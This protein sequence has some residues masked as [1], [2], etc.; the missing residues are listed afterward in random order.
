MKA[1]GLGNRFLLLKGEGKM[2]NAPQVRE[3]F[4]DASDRK[5]L[6]AARGDVPVWQLN[7][8]LLKNEANN[9]LDSEIAGTGMIHI[10][11]WMP[12]HVFA[13]LCAEA[14]GDKGWDK[15]P[16]VRNNEAWDLLYYA[17]ALC[18]TKYIRCERPNFWEHLPTWANP[19]DPDNP[20]I[21]KKGSE[22]FA[23]KPKESYDLAALASKI[24]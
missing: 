17:I 18:R 4:P 24:A 9:R 3:T 23:Q 8:N 13:E 20:F 12:H 2:P 21:V 19:L 15:L 11:K 7:S 5:N 1:K 6:A 10:P 16:G 22:P 14:L